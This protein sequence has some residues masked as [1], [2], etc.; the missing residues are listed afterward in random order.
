MYTFLHCISPPILVFPLQ[1]DAANSLKL[2]NV[3]GLFYILLVGL[4]LAVV[5]AV[6]E[7]IYKSQMEAKR[8]NVSVLARRKWITCFLSSAKRILTIPFVHYKLKKKRII[9]YLASKKLNPKLFRFKFFG[10]SPFCFHLT[11]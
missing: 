2:G 1:D 6:L 5:M 3:A 4:V 7:F 11:V 9:L 8:R 10:I